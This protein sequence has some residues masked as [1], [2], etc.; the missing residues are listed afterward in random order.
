MIVGA[1]F[2]HRGA[3]IKSAIPLFLNDNLD[4][5]GF[6][7][8]TPDEMKFVISWGSTHGYDDV[9]EVAQVDGRFLYQ[10]YGNMYYPSDAYDRPSIV[11]LC[12]FPGWKNLYTADD[13]THALQK[14][15]KRQEKYW[16]DL[17]HQLVSLTD[18]QKETILKAY[19]SFG[20]KAKPAALYLNMDRQ[21]VKQVVYQQTGEYA[22]E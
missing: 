22:W 17:K 13:I 12:F 14:N 10:M 2:A 9:H 16:Q 4:I 7:G 11:S 15:D 19:Q 18:Q 20:H 1:F 3:N 21:L 8:L 6:A 5:I